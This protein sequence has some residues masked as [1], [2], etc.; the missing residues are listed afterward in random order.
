[1]DNIDNDLQQQRLRYIERLA[2][3]TGILAGFE[4]LTYH[5]APQLKHAEPSTEEEW[6]HFVSTADQ[7]AKAMLWNRV[8]LVIYSRT[9][10]RTSLAKPMERFVMDPSFPS[11][12]L[13]STSVASEN[14][15][16]VE[17]ADSVGAPPTDF[18]APD[19]MAHEETDS[20]LE[21]SMEVVR[22]TV[23]TRDRASFREIGR[24]RI[25]KQVRFR[26]ESPGEKRSSKK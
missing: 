8:G 10:T 18:L 12:A 2:H 9:T 14:A 7:A 16:R 23:P 24:T 22:Q 25:Y 21:A 5:A 3:E 6:E 13:Q 17:S 19:D 1:V 4:E 26:K 20:M 15:D 11:T